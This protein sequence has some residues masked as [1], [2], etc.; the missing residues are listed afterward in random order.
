MVN[1]SQIKNFL[2]QNI[3]KTLYNS[4]CKPHMEFGII[5]WG[6]ISSSKLKKVMMVQKKCVRNVAGKSYRSHTD[7]LFSKLHILKL[8]DLLI[9]NSCSFIHKWINGKSPI[10]F[11]NTFTSLPLPN[12]TNSLQ[13]E[14]IKNDSL[15]HF[16]TDFLPKLWNK[17]SI[18]L[19]LIQSHKVFKKSLK[20]TLILKYSPRV[21]CKSL[22]CPDCR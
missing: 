3:R 1:L 22:T 2:P 8:E 12:R 20:E 15:L 18:D 5:A 9:Y 10:S 6:G 11:K 13:L 17:N 4:L 19:K 7:P 21:K 16:P 14:K